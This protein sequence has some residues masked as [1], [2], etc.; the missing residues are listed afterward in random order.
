MAENRFAV[1]R[2]VK[3]T[4]EPEP[5]MTP[6]PDM[7][8][9]I[10]MEPKVVSKAE[11]KVVSKSEPKEVSNSMPRGRVDAVA[12]AEDHIRSRTDETP[13]ATDDYDDDEIPESVMALFNKS[14]AKPTRESYVYYHR[15]DFHQKI[16]KIAE[17]RRKQT[18]NRHIT[19]GTVLD[20]I[21][22]DYFSR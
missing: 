18:G 13:A 4:F 22:E 1:K 12:I 7:R 6:A 14:K 17:I 10:D 16:V 15:D 21:L 9:D 8:E 11:S 19:I 20:D 5:E 2:P 3:R